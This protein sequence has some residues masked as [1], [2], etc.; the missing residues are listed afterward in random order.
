[1]VKE[2]A[3]KCSHCG[4]NG[5]NS[6]TC[7]GK[8]C[9]K[10]FGRM[11]VVEKDESI[12]KI[13]STGNLAMCHDAG[14]HVSGDA[15]YLSDGHIESGRGKGERKRG[16]GV[17]W[18]E[19]EHT[20]FLFGLEKLGKGDWRG[21]SKMYVTTR[22]PTQVASHAQKYFIRKA[23]TEKKKRRSSLFDMPLKEP[24]N[25]H[26]VSPGLPSNTN[27]ETSE[28]QHVKL[29]SSGN[30]IV[31]PLKMTLEVQAK[32]ST[33]SVQVSNTLESP[34]FT[35][36]AATGGMPDF[37]CM[38]YMVGIPNNMPSFAATKPVSFVYPNN[39]GFVYL[40]RNNTN[41]AT[42]CAPFLSQLG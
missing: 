29:L 13:K 21:I 6:R 15:G 40:P 38:P 2:S 23:A 9:F 22:T 1:M 39:Q 24:A 27:V 32:A 34:K 30:S 19:D 35:P 26:P 31:S 20:S 8:G 14:E 36:T 28:N 37:R 18:T 4:H 12:R 17:P 3:R 10:L 7:N 25:S 11:I 42:T 16:S 5:H 41:F 33:S